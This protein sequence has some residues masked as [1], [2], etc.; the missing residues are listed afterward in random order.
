MRPAAKVSEKEK[1]C[2]IRRRLFREIE[3]LSFSGQVQGFQQI[4]GF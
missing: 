1:T 4:K 2:D 3:C